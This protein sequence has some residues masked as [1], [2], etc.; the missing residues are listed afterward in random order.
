MR[1]GSARKSVRIRMVSFDAL[2]K[3][4]SASIFYLGYTASRR[5][6]ARSD[7]AEVSGLE[8]AAAA[9]AGPIPISRCAAFM[10]SFGDNGR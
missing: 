3:L 4:S 5:G 2:L 7:F 1:T 9:M 10:R 8:A 6:Q